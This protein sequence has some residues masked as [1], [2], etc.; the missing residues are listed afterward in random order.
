MVLNFAGTVLNF[1]ILTRQYLPVFYFRDLDKKYITDI[2]N[3]SNIVEKYVSRVFISV[4]L[5][6]TLVSLSLLTARCLCVENNILYLKF[7]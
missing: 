4:N 5:E 3:M 2:E 6:C 7:L 1:A